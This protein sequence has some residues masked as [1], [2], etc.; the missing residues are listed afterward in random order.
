MN[1]SATEIANLL[2][3]YAELLDGGDLEGVAELFRHAQFKLQDGNAA[4]G[5]I[6]LLRIFREQVKIYSCGTPRTKHLVTNPII[7]VNEK[8]GR[9][10]ARS[11]Y[12]V[13]QGTDGLQLQPIATGRYH[14]AF[15]RIDGVWRF[16]FRDYSMLD[17]VGDLSCH[18]NGAASR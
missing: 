17:M 4:V 5:G 7:E 18:L 9:A 8:S 6:E 16:S 13:L 10:T 2:Y 11:Y 1:N 3:R 12:T 14:D 15:E